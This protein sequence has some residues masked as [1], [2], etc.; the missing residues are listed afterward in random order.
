MVPSESAQLGL[1]NEI[2]IPVS[3]DHSQIAKLAD[4][5]ESI[6]QELRSEIDNVMKNHVP[7]PHNALPPQTAGSWQPGLDTQPNEKVQQGPEMNTEGK[8]E[9]KKGLKNEAEQEL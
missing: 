2:S 3:A 5:S 6:Y 4:G 8:Q 7:S 9:P 1:Q